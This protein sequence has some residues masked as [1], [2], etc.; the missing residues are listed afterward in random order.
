[1]AH[2]LAIDAG[3]TGVRAIVFDE[4]RA[5]LGSSYRELTTTYPRPAWVEQDPGHVRDSTLAVIRSALDAADI[6]G[7]D[8]DAI[9][10]A[11]QRS[12]ICAWDRTT[13]EPLSPLINW[14]DTRASERADEMAARGFLCTPGMAISKAEWI[15][16]EIA[17]AGEAA[18]A[19]R[20]AIGGVES[21]ICAFLGGGVNVTDHASASTT[22]FYSHLE[23]DYDDAVLEA[24]SL[25][26]AMLPELVD[27]SAIFAHSSEAILGAAVPIGG[28]SGDQQASLFGLGCR[29]EGQ[30][31]CTFGTAAMIELNSGPNITMGGEGTYPLVGWRASGTT[32]WCVEG[33]VITAGAAVQWLRDGLGLLEN[34]EQSAAVAQSVADSGGVWAVPAFQGLGTP[35]GSPQ[36]RAEICGLSRAAS[37][38]HVVRAVLEGVAQRV[39]DAAN[40]V[41]LTADPPASLRADGGA[42]R[43]DFLMQR[44]ADFLGIPVERSNES[45][46][47]A[48]GA[49]ALAAMSTGI[50]SDG[51]A[52]GF[53]ADR[54]F[55]P[56][57]SDDE[58][59]ALRALWVERVGRTAAAR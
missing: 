7:G 10:I 23:N 48:V 34:I 52:G 11:N 16:R 51:W 24:F 9:G 39:V 42:S 3:T 30:A 53:V 14:Q 50:S 36:A 13:L 38:A 40:T 20:L 18:K 15:V 21:W 57:I 44:V 47:S 41:W 58:R 19:G 28:I 1:M 45:D 49:A 26:R 43:N 31:K 22:G 55:E 4:S 12:S 35:H 5:V 56:S 17:A 37:R 27:S 8:L 46:G 54:V 59:E 6:S 25:E 32:V 33:A 2:I 29:D